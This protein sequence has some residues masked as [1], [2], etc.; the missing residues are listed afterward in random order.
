[1][2]IVGFIYEQ[3][4]E[5]IDTKTLKAPGEMVEVNGHK[6][7]LYCTGENKNGN[8][9][10]ILEAGAGNMFSV[11]TN[12]QK[13]LSK[14]TRV[15]SYDR[16][17][18]GFSESGKKPHTPENIEKDFAVLMSTFNPSD[19]FVLVG[20]S[21]G[22]IYVRDYAKNNISRIK[23]LVFIDSSHEDQFNQKISFLDGLLGYSMAG[24]FRGS[25][26][27]GLPRVVFAMFPKIPKFISAPGE[28]VIYNQKLWVRPSQ[29]KTSLA[30]TM[31]TTNTKS[32]RVD[33]QKIPI[34]VLSA[35]ENVKS[36]PQWLIW[37]KDIASLS[38][39]GKQITVPNSSHYIFTDQPQIVID[40]IKELLK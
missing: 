19:Q 31:Y 25:S 15:C 37:Q 20:H 14:D 3:I 33:L 30:E 12:I 2:I 32:V 16:S 35:E 36:D 4:S 1:M 6:M 27:V 21:I 40:S 17:G 9:T 38:D 24:L 8:P 29:I 11:W 18:I 34:V 5:Y 28:N 10:V 13:E 39:H 22:G 26:Y 23:G 7:H